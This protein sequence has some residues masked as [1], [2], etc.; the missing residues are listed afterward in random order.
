MKK[1]R[2]KRK[3]QRNFVL[4]SVLALFLLLA[5]VFSFQAIVSWRDQTEKA[6]LIISGIMEKDDSSA[7]Y[8]LVSGV[9]EKNVMRVEKIN[10][11][12]V[13][14]ET[15]LKLAGSVTAGG[16]DSGFLADYRFRVFHKDNAVRILFLSRSASLEL[17]RSSLLSLG[18]VMIASL[19]AASLIL[20]AVSGLVV[21]P[22]TDNHRRQKEFITGAGHELKT[23]LTVM[24]TDAELL[25][26][27]TGPNEWLKDLNVQIDRM[28]VM[29]ERMVTL[30]RSEELR[31]E[32]KIEFSLSD[33]VNDLLE[34][35]RAVFKGKGRTLETGVEDN[36]TLFGDERGIRELLA[37]LFDNAEKY[38]PEGG[39][40]RLSLTKRHRDAVICVENTAVGP[41]PAETALLTERFAR[42]KNAGSKKGFGLGLA[43]ADSV[44][45]NHHG[46]L[47]VS[48][49]EKDLFSVVCTLR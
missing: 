5:V 39:R 10:N 40:I 31:E 27:E 7:R 2:M 21:K 25:E 33:A 17:Y 41:D 12:S 29:T 37:I 48:V 26:T 42:G 22:I 24:K 14:N 3:L 1:D 16:K 44:A 23:P 19:F 34:S 9:P 45:K 49:P 38:C 32:Q 30:A 47:S 6:D 15:A 36:V 20:I 28:A 4:L 43:I 18:I 8:F 46:T 35:Y 13:T 11:L